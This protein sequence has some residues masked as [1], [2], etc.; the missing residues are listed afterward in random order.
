MVERQ[1]DQIARRLGMDPAALRLK[2]LL[3]PGKVNALGQVMQ[4]YNGRAD[5][6]LQAVTKALDTKGRPSTPGRARGHGIACFMKSPVMRTNAQ[7]GA[8]IRFNDDG[9]ANR[10]FHA[11]RKSTRLNSSHQI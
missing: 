8:I 1:M 7:S 10:R 5:L 9:S 6:C 11:D 3:L 2:N 4:N